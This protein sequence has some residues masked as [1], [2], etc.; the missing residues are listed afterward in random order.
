LVISGAVFEK[1]TIQ[2]VE[3]FGEGNRDQV[4]ATKTS[5]TA[6]Y[7]AFLRRSL[8]TDPAELR[9]E[10]VVRTQRDETVRLLTSTAS[11]HLRDCRAQIVESEDCE[12]TA[13]IYEG[14]DDSLEKGTLG[15][16]GEGA[17]KFTTAEACSHLEEVDFLTAPGEVD[18]SFVPV[19]LRFLPRLMRQWN[20]R[21]S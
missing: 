14:S 18:L 2:V 1:L 8:Q 9:I 10:K 16:P 13:E 21:L 17:V 15:L 19:D 7:A 12:N 11:K 4:V 6:L 20:I 3:V 5:D